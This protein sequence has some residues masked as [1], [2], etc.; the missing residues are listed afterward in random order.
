MIKIL[1]TADWHIDAPLRDFTDLQRRQL[2]ASLLEMP[3]KIA[4]LCIREG[5]DLMLL[6]G[7]VFDGPY[8][9][10]GYEAVYR[11]LERVQIPVFISPGNHDPYREGSVWVREAWPENVYLFRH[12]EIT[13]FT[14]R[15][16]D[17]RIYGAAF[18]GTDCPAL[19]TDFHA[20]GTERYALLVVHGDPTNPSSPY[21]PITAAQVREAGVDYAALGHIHAQGRFEAG[22]GICAWPGCPMGRGFDET[23]TKGV[24]IAELEETVRTRFVPLQVPRFFAYD[25]DVSGDPVAAVASLLPPGGSRDHYRIRLTGE[26]HKGAV[27]KY[28]S[29]V[30]GGKESPDTLFQS[31]H[32][33]NIPLH[34]AF[35]KIA[36]VDVKKMLHAAG[37]LD[38]IAVK[39]LIPVRK[40]ATKPRLRI[41]RGPVGSGVHQVDYGLRRGKIELPVQKSAFGEL[42]APGKTRTG[43]KA[44]FKHTARGD[45]P[46][47][48]LKL[49]DILSGI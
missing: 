41:V 13:S 12:R 48:A 5:C 42:S 22:A 40:R 27:T 28:L 29:L 15:E 18:T 8:T 2:R 7:D 14:I 38:G 44:G 26:N 16:L 49:Y 1:H 6:C 19:L 4:E 21:N 23:G 33:I 43:R 31:A 10:E 3:G 35:G 45:A 39:R 32:V 20:E 25:L 47:V 9:R 17:C 24:L 11:A 30:R 34:R 37:R 36:L 46:A